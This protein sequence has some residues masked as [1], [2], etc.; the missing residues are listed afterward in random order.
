MERRE[1]QRIVPIDLVIFSKSVFF[2]DSTKEK[3]PYSM[4]FEISMVIDR[5]ASTNRPESRKTSY[6]LPIVCGPTEA[7]GKTA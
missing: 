7:G 2:G 3:K 6:S 4:S 5:K 1:A